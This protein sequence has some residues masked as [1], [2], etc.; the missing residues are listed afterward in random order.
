MILEALNK[1]WSFT[2]PL[3]IK[4][5]DRLSSIKITFFPLLQ[6]FPHIY[7]NARSY[8][9]SSVVQFNWQ[10]SRLL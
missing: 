6:M 9:L 5:A 10:K 2:F 1:R 4:Q 7:F 3:Q 8:N